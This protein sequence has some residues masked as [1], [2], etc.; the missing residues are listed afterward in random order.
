MKTSYKFRLYPNKGQEEKLLW[1]LEKCRQTY[2]FF[3]GEL[4]NQEIIDKSLI[5]GLL[6]DMKICEPELNGV[7]SKVLQYECY[8]LFSNLKALSQSKKNGRKVGA[9]RFKGRGWFKT[10]TYNQSGFKIIETEKRLGILHLS[11]IGDIPLRLHRKIGGNI[12]Q[13]TIKHQS[14][15]KW[16]AYISA[17]ITE[18]ARKPAN[19]KKI[20]IDLG[21]D[22]FVHDSDGKSFKHPKFL[23]KSLD[24]LGKVQRKLSKKKKGSKNRTRQR[25]KVARVHEKVVSQRNDFLHKLS[26]HYV[27]NYGFIAHENLNVGGMARSHH[28]A[29]SIMDAS[30]SRFTQMLGYKAERAGIQ[31][32]GV[33]PKGTTQICSNCGR[34]VPKNLSDRMHICECGLEIG[35]DYNSAI[36]VLKRAIGREPPEFTPLEIG[37]PPAR[38]SPVYELGS[39]LRK[40]GS[41]SPTKD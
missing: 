26:K 38:A 33:D 35:R 21:L 7:H 4:N 30:W 18:E 39:P 17:E 37:P 22:N 27:D 36:Y 34:L 13:V 20:G 19:D 28:F 1:T 16:F 25:I 15:G 5:Q 14:S 9:L 32:V 10:F 2:N 41:S 12:K 6:P 40:L 11:K 24:K 29:K 31:I 8:R 3:L 23:R